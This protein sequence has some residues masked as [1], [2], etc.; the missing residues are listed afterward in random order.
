M[1][2]VTAPWLEGY[3]PLDWAVYHIPLIDLEADEPPTAPYD[4]PFEIL[5]SQSPN[6]E[7]AYRH[8]LRTHQP[9]DPHRFFLV[10]LEQQAANT[11]PAGTG[12]LELLTATWRGHPTGSWVLV[13]YRGMSRVP[14]CITYL[15]AAPRHLV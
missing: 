15:V 8:S 1:N 6:V 12:G 7:E 14:K 3:Q 13:S 10:D 4:W 5:G 9:Y 2:K 11:K